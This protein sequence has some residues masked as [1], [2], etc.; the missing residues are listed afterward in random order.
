MSNYIDEIPITKNAEWFYTTV[1]LIVIA[2]PLSASEN[3][4]CKN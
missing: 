2:I 4:A 1:P 3:E